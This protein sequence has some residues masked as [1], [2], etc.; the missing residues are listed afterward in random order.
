MPGDY[1]LSNENELRGVNEMREVKVTWIKFNPK[2]AKAKRQDVR[3]Y[4]KKKVNLK[5]K[6]RNDFRLS[7][8]CLSAFIIIWLLYNVM[9]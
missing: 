2:Y 6:M 4:S 9:V 3:R 1:R 8:A 7:L 5:N